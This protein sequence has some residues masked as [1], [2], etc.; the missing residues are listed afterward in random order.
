MNV[1]VV[2]QGDH[3]TFRQRS[4]ADDSLSGQ[5]PGSDRSLSGPVQGFDLDKELARL[6]REKEWQEGRRNAIT[7]R[8][9][10]GL[11][12]V[13]LAMKAGDR[14]EEHAAPGPIALVVREGRILFTAGEETVEAGPDRV[15]TCDAG[16]RHSVEA[17]SDAVCL[18]TVASG[19]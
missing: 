17:L 18:L 8:K 15:L 7:L 6:R 11:S 9:G 2:D 16:V 19:G 4:G 14:L 12:V 1:D 10:G 5:R 3:M 13:L